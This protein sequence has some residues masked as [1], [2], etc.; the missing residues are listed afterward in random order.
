MLHNYVK[1]KN[2]I[3]LYFKFNFIRDMKFMASINMD[4]NRS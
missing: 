2:I 1:Y 4:A 3:K